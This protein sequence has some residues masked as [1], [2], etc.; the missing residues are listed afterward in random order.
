M[1]KFGE[2]LALILIGIITVGFYATFF[3]LSAKRSF[4]VVPV[5]VLAIFLYA[6]VNRSNIRPLF[7]R[8]YLYLQLGFLGLFLVVEWPA[9]QV[10]AV[11]LALAAALVTTLWSRRV[12]APIVFVREKPLRRA[13]T[14]FLALA[15]FSYIAAFHTLLI[16]FSS[17]AGPVIIHFLLAMSVAIG[18]YLLWT[19][20]YN[21]SIREFFIPLAVIFLLAVEASIIASLGS[22]GYFIRAFGITL[23]WYVAQLFIRFHFGNRDIVWSRQKFFLFG[24]GIVF[25]VF[26]FL[27]RFL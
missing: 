20:Y 22:A 9:A 5:L 23:L 14:I 17:L 15:V 11:G 27:I 6:I 1:I 10:L 21:S 8:M 7:W 19:L 4:I 24:I 26:M 25:L 13:V 16:F 3:L 12:S 2:K 18:T